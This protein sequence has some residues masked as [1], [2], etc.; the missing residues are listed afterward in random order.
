MWVL[1]LGNT[2]AVSKIIGSACDDLSI[3][4]DGGLIWQKTEGLLMMSATT[5]G[6][7]RDQ[8]IRSNFIG[9]D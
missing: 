3:V 5:K 2:R 6:Y 4:L 9:W 8:A 7:G 1:F